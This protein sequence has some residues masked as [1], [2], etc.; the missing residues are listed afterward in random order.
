MSISWNLWAFAGD[1]T[2]GTHLKI[3]RD[4]LN[5]RTCI[6]TGTQVGSTTLALCDIFERVIT[7]EINN[8]YHAEAVHRL[9]SRAQCVKGESPAFLD[10]FLPDLASEAS[11]LFFLDAHGF[12]HDCPLLQELAMIAKH[13]ANRHDVIAIHDFRVPDRPELGFDSYSGWPISLEYVDAGM[14]AIW[15]S[16]WSV[17][18]NDVATGGKRGIAFF[19][20]K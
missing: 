1:P 18:F 5:I 2:I 16:G 10:E 11:L 12:G 4:A 6:E 20:S 14:N 15:P 19:S 7:V 9:N 3:Y 13:R 17:R 8:E